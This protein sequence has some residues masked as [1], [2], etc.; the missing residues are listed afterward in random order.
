MPGI[1][2]VPTR[3]Q[4]CNTSR[5]C[6]CSGFLKKI[7]CLDKAKSRPPARAIPAHVLR[8][9][10]TA[11]VDNGPPIRSQRKAPTKGKLGLS[12]RTV[13]KRRHLEKPRSQVQIRPQNLCDSMTAKRQFTMN[14]PSRS[15]PGGAAERSSVERR[16]WQPCANLPYLAPL[17]RRTRLQRLPPLRKSS[18]LAPLPLCAGLLFSALLTVPRRLPPP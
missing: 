3:S 10:C 15:E 2:A 1:A 11:R 17:P 16:V 14:S 13:G 12:Q 5:P 18:R 9:V 7:N 6:H 4:I 8:W